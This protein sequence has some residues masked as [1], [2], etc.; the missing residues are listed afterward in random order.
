MYARTLLLLCLT[1]A[2]VACA[3]PDPD[4]GVPDDHATTDTTRFRDLDSTRIQGFIAGRQPVLLEFGGHRCIS[5]M[6]MR[7]H[8]SAVAAKHPSLRIGFVYWEDSPELLEQWGVDMIP[9]QVLLNSAGAE[10][11]RHVGVWE[12]GEIEGALRRYGLVAAN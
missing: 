9:A 11:H 5:C 6:T 10:V 2:S 7:R 4:P 8:L 3:H 1:F 12:P